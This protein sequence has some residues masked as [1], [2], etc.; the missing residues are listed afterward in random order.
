MKKHTENGGFS[1]IVETENENSSF[2]VT[3]NR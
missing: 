3:E 1:G 2:L